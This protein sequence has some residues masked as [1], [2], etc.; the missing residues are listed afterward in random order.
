MGLQDPRKLNWMSECGLT[1]A[2]RTQRKGCGPAVLGLAA[3]GTAVRAWPP[4]RVGG[5][6]LQVFLVGQRWADGERAS[7]HH[8]DRATGPCQEG[9]GSW[10]PWAKEEIIRGHPEERSHK[11]A[12]CDSIPNHLPGL[13]RRS[14]QPA[15]L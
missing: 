9:L 6:V 10:F 3:E 4:P 1:P 11:H 2:L 12:L 8:Y 14:H 7:V 15:C 5:Q 13:G